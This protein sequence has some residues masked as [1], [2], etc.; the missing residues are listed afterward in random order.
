MKTTMMKTTMTKMT[1]I[2]TKKEK[3][4]KKKKKK[5]AHVTYLYVQLT[6]SWFWVV[7]DD[8]RGALGLALVTNQ[9]ILTLQLVWSW[10]MIIF[11]E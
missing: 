10:V 2:K 4:E 9:T 11:R 1:K 3:K 6:V 8:R 7:E 5:P